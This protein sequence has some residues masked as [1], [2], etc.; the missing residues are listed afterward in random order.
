MLIWSPNETLLFRG[1]LHGIDFKDSIIL[2][3]LYFPFFLAPS[4]VVCELET[5]YLG[6]E[7]HTINP[8]TQEAE[9]GRPL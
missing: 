7:E 5:I 3:L 8:S 6:M 9:A 1:R 4:K 2:G